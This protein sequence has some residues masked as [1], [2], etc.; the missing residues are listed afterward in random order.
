MGGSGGALSPR[1][2][3]SRDCTFWIF[4]SDH[5]LTLSSMP[6]HKFS[7]P[8]DDSTRWVPIIASCTE[9][10]R[11][12]GGFPEGHSQSRGEGGFSS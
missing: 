9:A 12:K 2:L 7:V 5:M 10:R 1:A 11:G 4:R 3:G 8:P 6:S